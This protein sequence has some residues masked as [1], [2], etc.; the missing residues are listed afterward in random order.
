VTERRVPD[1]PIRDQVLAL[2]QRL[3]AEPDIPLGGVQEPVSIPLIRQWCDAIGDTNA[4]YTDGPAQAGSPHGCVVAPPAMLQVWTMPGLGRKP[5]GTADEMLS[6]LQAVG[7]TG[8]VATNCEQAYDRY[9]RPGERLQAT[10]RMGD[11]TGPKRTSLGEGYFVTWY[12]TWFSGDEQVG[13][14]MF[15]VLQ[16]RPA[17]ADGAGPADGDSPADGA[18]PV[19]RVG[20]ADGAGHAGPPVTGEDR[21]PLRPAID[22]DTRFFWEGAAAGELRIQRCHG[23][24]RLRHPPGPVCPHCHGTSHGYAVASGRGEVFSYVV[25]HH[26]PVAGRK[27]PFVVAVIELPEGVRVVGNILGVPADQV[28]VGMPVEVMFERADAGLV[29]PQWKAVSD[30]TDVLPELTLP[31]TTTTVVTTAIATRDFTAVHHDRAAARAQGAPDVFL[32]ILTTMGFTQRFVTDWAGPSALVRSISVRLGAPACAG[33]TLTLTG[34]VASRDSDGSVTV[35]VRG[36]CGLGD[37]VTATVRLELP[38]GASVR[39]A[40][41]PGEPG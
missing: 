15:R 33:D 22:Q 21:Y 32:N 38:E 1:E 31:L 24:G 23:C 41:Q 19:G 3:A 30:G 2:A 10:T 28:R 35:A 8:I 14:M 5:E 25:H 13:R 6:L 26:P 36:A 27:A 7:Y 29:L 34:N 11:V 20:A 9:L 37:H 39:P 12:T 17:L 40:A 16:F 4:A 18:G